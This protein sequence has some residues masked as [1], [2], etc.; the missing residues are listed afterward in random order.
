MLT[1]CSVSV[2]TV[3]YAGRID[4]HFNKFTLS[5]FII[6]ALLILVA[7]ALYAASIYMILGRLIRAVGGEHLSLIPTKWVTRIFVGGDII[8][9]TMQAG[10]GGI[11]SGGTLKLFNL[12]EKVITGGLF[13]QI[14]FFGFFVFTTG[15]FHRAL[16]AHPTTEALR[17]VVPWRRHLAT[18]YTTSTLILVRSIVR[19]IEYLQGNAGFVIS[20]EIFL[21]MFDFLLMAAVM[22]IL[23]VFYVGDLNVAI[24]EKD[25]RQPTADNEVILS[26]LS[27]S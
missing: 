20:H 6:Q 23:F 26:D 5:G 15:L 18:L 12:G 11:Q 10:G 13:A 9:F 14:I 21:Y 4:S 1:L 3:G 7:P 27:G 17:N 2:E 8:A 25:E 19:V 24:Q 16:I 22:A